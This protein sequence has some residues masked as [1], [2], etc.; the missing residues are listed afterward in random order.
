MTVT[1]THWTAQEFVSHI[2]EVLGVYGA[3][4]GYPSLV[5]SMRRDQ[6]AAHADRTDFRAI[7][8]LCEDT[9][10]SAR[11]THVEPTEQVANDNARVVV[12]RP[13]DGQVDDNCWTANGSAA[14]PIP[15]INPAPTHLGTAP[16]QPSHSV[17]NGN[18]LQLARGQV[19]GFAYGYRSTAGQWWHDCVSRGLAKTAYDAWFRDCFEI[20][21]LHVSPHSQG[22]GNGRQLL[23]A[24]LHELPC[25]TALLSTPE[26][27]GEN[28]RAWHLYRSFGFVDVLRH[29]HF[30]GDQ[31][32][33]AILGRKAS[34]SSRDVGPNT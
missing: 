27:A 25:A 4:M 8:A 13:A 12:V 14:A 5:V 15:A 30:P 34:R 24:L 19:V 6:I 11:S 1:L 22:R 29:H 28:S 10:D 9:G 32:P 3:A 23:T 16:G 33:F 17:H 7:A 2:D 21:E 31:R 26:V 20:A 18:T